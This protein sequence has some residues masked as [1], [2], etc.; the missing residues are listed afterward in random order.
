MSSLPSLPSVA[1]GREKYNYFPHSHVEV[2][3]VSEASE[4][5]E[6]SITLFSVFSGFKTIEP[7]Y[8][9]AVT[10]RKDLKNVA[11]TSSDRHVF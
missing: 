6:K 3:F 1:S 8:P 5:R 9:T 10:R 11:V 4:W 2:N 7:T